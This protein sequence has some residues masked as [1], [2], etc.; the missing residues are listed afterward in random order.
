[1]CITFYFFKGRQGLF[2]CIFP[3]KLLFLHSTS[4]FKLSYR[5]GFFKIN[6]FTQKLYQYIEARLELAKMDTEERIGKASALLLQV[7]LLGMLL[8]TMLL[9]L[10]IALAL[11]LNTFS[12]CAGAPYMGFLIVAGG[13]CV[14]ILFV[15]LLQNTLLKSTKRW[16]IY[17]FQKFIKYIAK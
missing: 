17:S 7:I 11:Y 10:N 5:L 16:V 3:N 4:S 2:I 1:M 6:E 12:F 8:G 15:I 14:M 13:H 9:F